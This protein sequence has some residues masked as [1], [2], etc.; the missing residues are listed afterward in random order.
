[1]MNMTEIQ[2]AWNT[3]KTYFRTRREVNDAK[4]ATA[5]APSL[6]NVYVWFNGS[7]Y[8]FSNGGDFSVETQ[9]YD[10]FVKFR[11][12]QEEKRKALVQRCLEHHDTPI[13][14]C[15]Y[16]VFADL[17]CFCKPSEVK[18]AIKSYLDSV[19]LADSVTEPQWNGGIWVATML[20]YVSYYNKNA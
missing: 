3:A 7:T 19:G 18:D 2:Y 14:V 17:P 15:C 20:E 4:L 10:K 11:N 6:S 9:S 5:L 8:Y 16:S 1:M 12:G 13:R